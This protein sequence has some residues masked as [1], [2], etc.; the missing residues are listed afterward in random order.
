METDDNNN[1]DKYFE[2]KNGKLKK[3]N[4]CYGCFRNNH[5]PLY[6]KEDVTALLGSTKMK[7]IDPFQ[8]E[9]FWLH[10]YKTTLLFI[11]EDSEDRYGTFSNIEFDDYY[12]STAIFQL[13]DA[14]DALF[15]FYIH[16]E[17]ESDCATCDWGTS[18]EV[19]KIRYTSLGLRQLLDLVWTK[20]EEEEK[21]AEMAEILNIF[22]PRKPTL[23][24]ISGRI[25]FNNRVIN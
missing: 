20:K 9:T 12:E 10:H 23:K 22:F 4:V 5:D 15:H 24:E 13:W 25:V 7:F 1:I 16:M 21:S 8:D 6:D 3:Y 18:F 19:L 2:K 14:N 11:E 17:L